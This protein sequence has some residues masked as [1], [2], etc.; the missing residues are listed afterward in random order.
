MLHQRQSV[1]LLAIALSLALLVG[2][3]LPCRPQAPHESSTGQH[4][5]P[6]SESSQHQ[7]DPAPE[8]RPELKP[9]VEALRSMFNELKY[10]E[11]LQQADALLQQASEKGDKTGQAYSHRFRAWA[12]Q[13]LSRLEEAVVAW[14]QAHGL[15]RE[16]GDGVFEAEALLGWALCLWRTERAQAEGLIEQALGLAQTERRR[17]LAMAQVLSDSGAAWYG[18]ADLSVSR[19]CFEQALAIQKRFAPHSVGMA[20][21]LNNLGNIAADRGDLAAA[22]QYYE[23]AFAIQE[24]LAPNSREAAVILSGLG[25]TALYR[26]DLEAAQRYF[27]R[28][29]AIFEPLAPKS[30]EIAVILNSLGV[31]AYNRGDLSR[32]QQYYEQALGIYERLVPNSL[33]A[34]QTLNNLGL[35]AYNRGNLEESLRYFERSLALK[36][37]LVPDSLSVAQTLNNLGNVARHQGDLATAQQR[38]EQA[39]G[40]YER[41]A[42]NSLSVAQTLNNLGI[43]ARQRGDLALAQ[44]YYERALAIQEH[45]APNSLSVAQTLNNL[46]IVARQRGNLVTAQQRYEQA[47]GIYERMAPDSLREAV[48]LHNLGN[49]AIAQGDLERAQQYYERALIIRERLAPQSLEVADT[50]HNLGNVAFSRGDLERAQQ[51]L[52]QSLAIAERLAPNA[53][54]AAHTRYVLAQ[55]KLVQNQ[56]Q[57]ALQHLQRALAITE[58]QR[59]AVAD[60]ETR[61]LFSER[62]FSPYPILARAYLQ[63]KQPARAAETL[64]RSRARSLAETLQQRQLAFAENTP[65][66]LR[67]LLQQQQQLSAKRLQT[68][69]Q[70]QETN[71]D[72]AETIA[73]LQRTLRTLD[74]QQRT[75]DDRLRKEFPDYAN[76]VLP[77]PLGIQQIQQSLD[78]GTVLL[79]YALTED[80]LLIIAVSRT[81]VRGVARKVDVVHLEKQVQQLRAVLSKP[82]VFRNA[83]ERREWRQQSQWLYAEL[84]APMQGMLKNVQRVL[85]CPDGVL[86]QLPWA[87]LIVNTENGKPV[88]WIER[89]ALHLTPSVGVYRQARSVQPTPQGVAIT[90]VWNYTNGKPIDLAQ[91]QRLEA[92]TLLRRSGAGT[93]LEDLKHAPD[94]VDEL[95]KVF[96]KGARV[97]VN[98]QATPQRAQELTANA[99]VVHLLCHARA[100]HT[101]PLNSAL[102]LAPAGSDV[103]KLTAGEVLFHWR[104]RADLVM[105]SACE[106]GVGA[107][108]RYE[109]VYSLG[110]AFLAAGSRSVG[111]SLWAVSDK[112]TVELMRGFYNRYKRGMAKDE[113]LRAAQLELLRTP[114]HA[115]PYFWSAFVLMGDYR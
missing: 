114:Q 40:I 90:A 109:G 77:K 73:Q 60:P 32:A 8:P 54:E 98:A 83:L 30:L 28:A 81:E 21:T 11:T 43:V 16:L 57:A 103:G 100:D 2:L 78:A 80:H 72:D 55:L 52:E 101:D 97:A 85:L 110:R 104:L 89:V 49:V 38:Y 24:R 15:W 31:V 105:L 51:Y 14:R 71:A 35:V 67:Q 20:L 74:Q 91:N 17:P 93:V 41:L 58:T 75:L 26:G 108:R 50:L 25:S 82:P 106:T 70:L 56:P 3:S 66:P 99:R 68:Y 115:D 84:V 18:L 94:E 102:L 47:L 37:R 36:E 86:C 59:Q 4:Q 61:A 53:L 64:E 76:L 5:Q 92:A 48:V 112:A 113:A 19:R 62:Y 42:P 6:T 63:L 33:A 27:E 10:A 107:A 7:D 23:Q 111:M 9:Q 69:R 34:A 12:L 39:L 1:K 44:G 88:Y 65:N 79:Y 29:L 13:G 45:L 46:G 96:G 87:A 22:Q 95:R